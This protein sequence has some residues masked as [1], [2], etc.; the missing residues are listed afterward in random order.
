VL[1]NG[2]PGLFEV[3]INC[4][5][6]IGKTKLVCEKYHSARKCCVKRRARL[7]WIRD[8][9]W[10]NPVKCRGHHYLAGNFAILVYS[11]DAPF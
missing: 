1:N 9:E 3:R 4:L 8:S 5:S 10:V 11:A 7:Q 6:G 2:S